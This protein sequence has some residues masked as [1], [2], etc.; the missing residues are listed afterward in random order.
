MGYF[1]IQNILILMPLVISVMNLTLYKS[2]SK[3]LNSSI[4]SAYSSFLYCEEVICINHLVWT[5]DLA[6]LFYVLEHLIFLNMSFSVR[7][8]TQIKL[9][10]LCLL[11]GIVTLGNQKW[12]TFKAF[13]IKGWTS[14]LISLSLCPMEYAN[15]NLNGLKCWY[16]LQHS[17]IH[18]GTQLEV[19]PLS[20]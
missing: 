13:Y 3:S 16:T 8:N 2:A 9:K 5:I 1:Q 18:L 19:K 7:Y 17:K 10:I 11:W 15:C 14:V 20:A 4:E 6:G 12:V